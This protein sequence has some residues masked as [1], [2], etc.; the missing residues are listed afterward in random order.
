MDAS[1][2]EQ[3]H[4]FA[5]LAIAGGL[6]AFIGIEREVRGYPAGIRTIALVAL[7]S[8]LFTDASQF[9]PNADESRVAAQ[10]VSGIGFLGAGL[11]LRESGTIRGIT[12]AATVW[13]AA[14]L[15]DR[16]LPTPG[17]VA[18]PRPPERFARRC[19]AAEDEK[20]RE[21]RPVPPVRRDQFAQHDRAGHRR[22]RRGGEGIC[23]ASARTS[24]N[25]T[26]HT[27]QSAWVTI[28]SG[29]SS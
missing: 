10:V 26:A 1:T 16:G 25:E 13:A 14:A 20:R 15:V 27:A 7:G 2:T 22:P 21:H 3:L 29:P 8:C 19:R 5:R 28:R 11:I 24:S 9:F 6:G 4:I 12:T 17:A 18:P 23:S